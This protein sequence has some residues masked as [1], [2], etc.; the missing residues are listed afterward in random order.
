MVIDRFKDVVGNDNV[1]VSAHILDMYAWDYSF[2]SPRKPLAV[3]RPAD[4]DVIK[5]I[6][7]L[8]NETRTTLIPTSSGFPKFHGDTV[9]RI[10]GI[11][12]DLSH[13]D[14]VL[15]IDRR[16][17]TAMIEPGVTFGKLQKALE[18]E[19]LVPYTPLLPRS[20]KSVL[21]SS[22]EREPITIPKDHWDYNDP[23]AGG[24]VVIGDG[25]I[26]GFGDS[27]GWSKEELASGQF[28][29]VLPSGPSSIGWLTLVQGAQG[30]LGIVRW[31]S[32]RCRTKPSLQKPYFI[33]AD[34]SQTLLPFLQKMLKVRF[35]DELF[36]VNGLT[37]ASLFFDDP[38]KIS[39]FKTSLPPWV[40]FIALAGYERYPEEELAW[41]EEQAKGAALEMGQTLQDAV[42]GLSA[43]SFLRLLSEAAEKDY[44][45]RFKG[46]CQVLP[47]STTLD[48]VPEL[49]AAV[50]KIA[51]QN[52]YAPADVGMYFQP[53][54]QGC[55]CQAEVIF[56][57]NAG[58]KMLAEK[59]FTASAYELSTQGAYYSRPYGI[60][61]DITYRDAG[62]L[63]SLRKIK[64]IF[65]PNDIM[66]TGNL[67]Y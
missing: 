7:D 1:E 22:L 6:V 51:S 14:K 50:I 59:I 20:T 12:V 60:L 23:L 29:P 65:D 55:E 16:N 11:V 36:I 47:F 66:N 45:L 18:P 19:G 48:R 54:L 39:K 52:G 17:K 24:Q 63:N 49:T 53:V 40:L 37:L 61:A 34:N 41:K 38:E 46:L 2:T 15:R 58:E 56:P 42:S 28:I 3:I 31:A 30:T 26:Q 44:R 27:A 62:V 13:L 9:P 5:D 57:Y 67:H 32:I 35:A 21:A 33:A 8:A 10:P 64:G 25:H 43:V 4:T